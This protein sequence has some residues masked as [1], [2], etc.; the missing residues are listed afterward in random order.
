M[1]KFV[2]RLAGILNIKEKLEEQEKIAYGLARAHLTE[3]ENKLEDL[4][5]RRNELLDS[6][7]RQM[8]G[9]INAVDLNLTENAIKS[10]DLSIDDQVLNVKKAQKAL[11]NARIK[12]EHAMIERKTYE[13][14]KENAYNEYL[15]EIEHSE[16]LE[17]N[18]LVSY[19]H[20]RLRA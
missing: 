14:L 8:G 16:Q 15:Q 17:I 19:R 12:L 1:A 6:K 2:F 9:I 11:E 18:E 13:K 4:Y 10:T 7:K 3:E 20:G 5:R